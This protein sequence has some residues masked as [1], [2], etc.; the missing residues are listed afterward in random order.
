MR[1]PML[2]LLAVLVSLNLPLWADGPARLELTFQPE[3]VAIGGEAELRV[4]LVDANGQNTPATN[5]LTIELRRLPHAG[6]PPEA[7][8]KIPP[9]LIPA[10]S[11]T[12]AHQFQASDEGE[13]KAEASAEGLSTAAAALQVVPAMPTEPEVELPKDGEIVLRPEG[14]IHD[15]K[16]DGNYSVSFEACWREGGERRRPPRTV[17][18]RVA[19][20]LNRPDLKLTPAVLRLTPHARCASFTLTAEEAGVVEVETHWERSSGEPARV[21]LRPAPSPTRLRF[22]ESGYRFK[23]IREAKGTVIVELL[24][25]DDKRWKPKEPYTVRLNVEEH[26]QMKATVTPPDSQAEFLLKPKVFGAYLLT[27]TADDI[28]AELA[29][30][31]IFRASF[32]DEKLWWC[33]GGGLIAAFI[34]AIR[35]AKG[36]R[37]KRFSSGAPVA[38]AASATSF[39]FAH[40]GLFEWLVKED[41]GFWHAVEQLATGNQ[42]A[43]VVLGFVAGFGGDAVFLLLEGALAKWFPQ[44]F[45]LSALFPKAGP[46]N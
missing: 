20:L 41:E 1:S 30:R 2:A 16:R 34:Q 7:V 28:R 3:M 11:F 38:L 32:D 5:D 10:G 23:G 44:G 12:V 45:K 19:T 42:A 24:I 13:W 36:G 25:S 6:E 4:T 35:A 15:P 17:E 26:D 8:E 9:L 29:P 37:L 46:Q 18:F 21:E 31:T 14:Q 43:S 33:L 39:F 22:S 40:Y 27:A